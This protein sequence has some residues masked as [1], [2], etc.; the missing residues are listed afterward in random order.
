MG[1]WSEQ[2]GPVFHGQGY[3]KLELT[4]TGEQRLEQIHV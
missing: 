4:L 2:L 3:E 1:Y